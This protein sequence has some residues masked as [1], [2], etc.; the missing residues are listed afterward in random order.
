MCNHS[1]DEYV[2]DYED[3][4]EEAMCGRHRHRDRGPAKSP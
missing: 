3:E 1:L 2:H 4:Y